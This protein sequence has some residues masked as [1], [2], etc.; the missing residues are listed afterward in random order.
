[1]T[2]RRY[3]RQQI[4]K[5]IHKACFFCGESDYDLLDVH[6]IYEGSQGGTYDPRNT[7]V[8]CALCHRKIHA[9]RIIVHGKYFCTSGRWKVHFTEDGH[10]HWKDE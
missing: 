5:L 10:E 8:N 1:M 4:K 9:G 3:S 6:R 7:L 2:R